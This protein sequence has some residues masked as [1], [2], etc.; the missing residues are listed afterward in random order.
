MLFLF[1]IENTKY[2]YPLN[3]PHCKPVR[4]IRWIFAISQNSF[5]NRIIWCTAMSSN[6]IVIRPIILII[7]H[8]LHMETHFMLLTI[9]YAIN[10]MFKMMMNTF[11]Q[12]VI[13]MMRSLLNVRNI[14]TSNVAFKWTFR[15][16]FECIFYSGFYWTSI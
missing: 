6:G 15:K 5:I 12:I 8:P 3:H 9:P 11:Q 13:H 2:E 10:W 7:N 16:L 1:H 14:V 4:N